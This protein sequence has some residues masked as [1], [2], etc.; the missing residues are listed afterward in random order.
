[1]EHLKSTNFNNITSIKSFDFSTLYTTIPH[2]KLKSRLATCS[3]I[4]NSFM[5]KN[6]NHRYKYLV[7]GHEE[8]YFV[9]EH[10]DSKLKYSEDDIIK[11]L[12]FLVDNIFVV[13]AGKVLQQIVGIP[14][15]TNCAPLLADIFLYSYEAEFIHSL[16]STGRKQLAFRF[17]FT[18]RYIDDVLS[19]NNPEFEKNLGQMYPVELEI[20]DTTESN[21]SAS[22]LDLLLSIGRY[23]QLHTSIYDKR[24]DFN[25]HITNFPFLSSNIPTSPAYGVFISQLIRYAR[26][27]SSY[28]CFILKATRL[29]NKLLEQGYVKERLKSSLRKFYGRYGDLIKQYEVSLLT[30]VKWHSVTWPY[31]LTTP[32][33]SDLVPN[34]TFYRILSC[35]HRTF[36]TDVACRQGT[37]TPPDTWSH[38]F[39]TCI[40][41]TCWDQSFSELVVILPD[42]ALRISLGTFSILLIRIKWKSGDNTKQNQNFDNTIIADRRRTVSW[43]NNCHHTVSE[44][45]LRD[46]DL[47]TNWKNV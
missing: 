2:D 47:P 14:M 4:R 40:C 5:F 12:E 29:S 34:S 21:T 35:F 24:D 15:G 39:G 22:Y 41:S 11:M 9:K 42:Y 27:C 45:V 16:L 37:L 28:G 31:T 20:K 6:G 33:W 13:F 23:G 17:N 46:P 7:L 18:Y 32:Y 36:A 19:I 38:L 10:S 8:S 43:S 26:A 3:I 25:F 1:M 30:N 44:T